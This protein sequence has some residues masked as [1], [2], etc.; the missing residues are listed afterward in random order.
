MCVK[1]YFFV[2]LYIVMYMKKRFLMSIPI[3]LLLLMFAN[4]NG[5]NTLVMAQ[6]H[7][8]TEELIIENNQDKELII[9]K[10]Y[11]NK[12]RYLEF[13]NDNGFVSYIIDNKTGEEENFIYY[14]KKGKE[15]E[16]ENKINALISLKYPK[17]IS[18]VLIGN[19]EGRKYRLEDE[20]LVI[21]FDIPELILEDELTLNVYY[22]EIKDYLDF[23][24]LIKNDYENEDGY[25]YDKNKKTV[26]LTFDDG[27]S[28]NKTNRLVEILSNNKAHATFFMVGNKMGYSASV[29]NN[30]LENGNE[31]GSH[32]YDHKNMKRQKLNKVLEGEEKTKEIYKSIT[33]QDL[34]YTRPPYGSINQK[35]KDGL[36]TIFITWNLDTEDW[37]H[38][39]K[40]YIVNYVLENVSDG[41]II[42][43][44]DSY[45]TTIDAVE[46]LLPKLYNEGYQVV[47]VTELA[48][49]KEQILEK[50]NIYRS[51][52]KS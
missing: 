39:D 52:K 30:V 13:K 14:V 47:S 44:H 36:D 48:S 19:K 32:S 7:K 10:V 23:T 37:L 46:E 1:A 43:M 25:K 21:Y 18:E 35:I 8:S 27:P 15:E 31:I 33:G 29:I 42:L 24:M 3:L 40:D 28:G 49:L 5:G 41:D 11:D 22:N 45:D 6:N 38:R 34:I 12:F 2:I 20:K 17:Y 9:N 26:A 51:I 16:F 4:L 50:N